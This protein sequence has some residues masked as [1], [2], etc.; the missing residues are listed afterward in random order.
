M[1]APVRDAEKAKYSA[2][3]MMIVDCDIHPTQG[4]PADL[5]PYMPRQWLE[6][7]KSFGS[8][9]RQGLAQRI[10]WPRMMASGQRADAYPEGGGPPGSDYELLRRQHLDPNGVEHGML[11]ALSKAGMEERNQDYAAALASAANLWQLAAFVEKDSR[12]HAGIVVPSDDTEAAVKEIDRH[13]GDPRFAQII[14]SPRNGEALGRRRNWPIFARAQ[15]AG[16]PV[17][18]HPDAYPGG[19]ASTGSGWPTYYMQE[20]YCFGTASESIAAS[21][22]LEGVFEEFPRLKIAMIE[23]GFSWAPTLGWRMD[24][25][26]QRMRAEVPRLKRPPSE[27]LREHFWFATQPIEEPENPEHL[28]DIFDWIGWDHIMY[29]SDYPHWDYDDPRHILRVRIDDEKRARLFR[30]NA[31]ALYRLD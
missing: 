7:M 31:K 30:E 17:G 6:H 26:W 20:H 24:H 29:S 27:Y 12:L 1:N 9:V 22:V 3:K 4:S 28:L 14:L 19:V 11:I 13:A 10:M 2:Q 15:E 8:H 5:F 18:L 25:I 21:L 16:L 23:A